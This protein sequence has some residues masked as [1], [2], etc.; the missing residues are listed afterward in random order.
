MKCATLIMKK[1]KTGIVALVLVQCCHGKVT[2]SLNKGE[3][4][5]YL[6]ILDAGN[7]F[8]RKDENESIKGVAK[9]TKDSFEVKV[10]WQEFTT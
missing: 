8:S 9:T 2:K 6:G 3:S 1:G 4:Y 5:K 7:V 10:K